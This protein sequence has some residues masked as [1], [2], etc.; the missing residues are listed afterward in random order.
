MVQN[1]KQ[2][3]FYNNNSSENSAGV[4]TTNLISG[5]AFKEYLPLFQLGVQTIPGTKLYLNGNVNPVIV[6]F[7]G[8][9]AIDLSEGGSIT[10]IK[11]DAA[12]IAN[13]NDNNSAILVVDMAYLGGSD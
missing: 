12:S 2:I 11:F 5:D 9:L 13:I 6:G 8:L 7:T 1:Y 3:V 10:E 4:N